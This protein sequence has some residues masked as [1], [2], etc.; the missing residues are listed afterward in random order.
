MRLARVEKLAQA[1]CTGLLN[2]RGLLPSCRLSVMACHT[3]CQHAQP[4]PPPPA[5]VNLTLN[6]TLPMRACRLDGAYSPAR[7]WNY[8]R[9]Q[10][11]VMDTYACA[12]G[13]RTNHTMLALHA[14]LSWAFVAPAVLAA[15]QGFVAAAWL[16][17]VSTMYQ[18]RTAPCGCRTHSALH[19]CLFWALVARAMRVALY[20]SPSSWRFALAPLPSLSEH[21]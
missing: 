3:Y 14:C 10:L 15:L 18:S 17:Q 9:R 4:C 21:A 20:E 6:Q 7:Y 13:R 5:T 12:A 8:L 19:A 11:Y 2:L 1:P 16:L